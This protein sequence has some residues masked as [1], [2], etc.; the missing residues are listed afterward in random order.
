MTTH[1]LNSDLAIGLEKHLGKCCKKTSLGSSKCQKGSFHESNIDKTQEAA[2]FLASNL[3]LDPDVGKTVVLQLP[4]GSLLRVVPRYRHL[5]VIADAGRSARAEIASRCAGA[6]VSSAALARQVF[7]RAA[8]P[9]ALRVQIASACVAS[10]ALY[11][12]GTWSTLPTRL[13]R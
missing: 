4:S 5:G 11:G 7:A 13:L 2:D 12:A 3:V 6:R 1:S 8:L 10:R 9:Q